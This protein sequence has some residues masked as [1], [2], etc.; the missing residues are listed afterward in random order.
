VGHA[1]EGRGWLLSRAVRERRGRQRADACLDLLRDDGFAVD[2]GRPENWVAPADAAAVAPLL[3]DVGRGRPRVF[4]AVCSTASAKHWPADRWAALA[5]RLVGDRGCEIFLCGGPD[6]GARHAE[7]LAELA[8]GTAAHIHDLSAAVPLGHLN[9]LLARM[10]LCVGVDTGL[11]H[12]AASLGVPV[13]VLFGPTNPNQWHPWR[14]AGEVIRADR[15]GLAT[16]R[17]PQEGAGWP[18]RPAS[19]RDITVADVLASADRLLAE[20]AAPAR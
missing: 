13:A 9:A 11:P 2:D 5:D 1:S 16:A 4:F 10:D 6:D 8:P 20:S 3:D 14:A 18:S 7:L 19:M 15:D 17:R 12:V